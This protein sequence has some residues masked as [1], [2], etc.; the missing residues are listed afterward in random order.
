MLFHSD[1][2]L[3]RE[4][5]DRRIASA[6]H[7]DEGFGR[8]ARGANKATAVFLNALSLAALSAIF[9]APA[10][11]VSDFTGILKPDAFGHHVFSGWEFTLNGETH[12]EE[13]PA[14]LKAAQPFLP[15]FYLFIGLVF[16]ILARV[17]ASRS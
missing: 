6:P 13:G 8:N 14:F 7:R 17:F 11:S 3:L 15:Y 10:S 16:H 9:I 2:R 5:A 4:R 12:G 1:N